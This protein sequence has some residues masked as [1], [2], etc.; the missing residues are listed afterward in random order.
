MN[1]EIKELL[2]SALP[3]AQPT[4]LNGDTAVEAGRRRL[5]RRRYTAGGGALAGVAAV[6]VAISLAM[7]TVGGSGG[8]PSTGAGASPSA[9][10]SEKVVEPPRYEL[11]ELDH[12]K[13]YYWQRNIDGPQT[14]ET[15]AIT[16]RM[17]AWLSANYGLNVSGPRAEFLEETAVLAEHIRDGKGGSDLDDTE[18][19]GL[20]VPLLSLQTPG[21]GDRNDL[22]L[23]TDGNV[24]DNLNVRIW[25]AGSFTRPDELAYE[26]P[27]DFE[28]PSPGGPGFFDLARCETGEITIQLGHVLTIDPECRVAMGGSGLK[29][30][31]QISGPEWE[32]T[33]AYAVYYARNG[34]AIVLSDAATALESEPAEPTLDPAALLDLAVALSGD[35][36]T[37]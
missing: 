12:D 26:G 29:V 16:E 13:N 7:N 31:K 37:G 20:E 6:A 30:T 22:A 24:L 36:L 9:V 25:P 23:S 18:P 27:T 17:W 19:V 2:N 3:P 5:G 21:F 32:S 28:I 14:G 15:Q 10:A 33:E 11:P 34:S 4:A 8:V 35:G 1:D